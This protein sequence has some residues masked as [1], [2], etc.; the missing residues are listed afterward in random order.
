MEAKQPVIH[1]S[2]EEA[3]EK[4]L[5]VAEFAA[6]LLR[7]W[8]ELPPPSQL[9]SVSSSKALEKPMKRERN[10]RRRDSKGEQKGREG[11]KV[12]VRANSAHK[13]PDVD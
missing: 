1:I 5:P 8:F 3:R 13:G 10:K 11:K 2:S 7:P 6:S 12:Q 9:R 4:L